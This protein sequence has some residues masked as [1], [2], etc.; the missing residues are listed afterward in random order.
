[1]IR[2]SINLEVVGRRKFE[3]KRSNYFGILVLFRLVYCRCAGKN[4]CL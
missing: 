3:L 2:Y 4:G 1:M